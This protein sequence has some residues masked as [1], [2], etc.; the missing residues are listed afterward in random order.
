VSVAMLVV[1]AGYV[2]RLLPGIRL[3]ALGLRGSMPVAA[4]AAAAVALRLALWGGERPLWQALVEVAVFL[5]VTAL[6]TRALERDLLREFTRYV[7]TGNL[8]PAA[9]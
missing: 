8:T 7:R 1:R 3:W 6:A 4:G 5:G 9:A 2:H